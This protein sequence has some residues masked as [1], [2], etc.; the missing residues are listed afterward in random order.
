RNTYTQQN[1]FLESKDKQRKDLIQQV[2]D[3]FSLKLQQ[4]QAIDEKDFQSGL[5]KLQ[6][7][8]GI[9]GT[10]GN[11]SILN[12]AKEAALKQANAAQSGSMKLAMDTVAEA[13]ARNPAQARK[14]NQQAY[15]SHQINL[16]DYTKNEEMIGKSQEYSDLYKKVGSDK[17]L[18]D[19]LESIKSTFATKSPLGSSGAGGLST[20]LPP[21]EASRQADIISAAQQSFY[22][23]QQNKMDDLYLSDPEGKARRSNPNA[24]EMKVRQ[25]SSEA[26]DYARKQAEVLANTKNT[27]TQDSNYGEHTEA[28]NAGRQAFKQILTPAQEEKKPQDTFIQRR[29]IN[30][31]LPKQLSLVADKIFTGTEKEQKQAAKAYVDLYRIRGF[32]P[33]LIAGYTNR[34]EDDVQFTEKMAPQELVKTGQINPYQDRLFQSAEQFNAYKNNPTKLAA[35]FKGLGISGKDQIKV[36]LAQDYLVKVFNPPTLDTINP[37]GY[38]R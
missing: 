32:N 12:E 31:T 11:L 22:N 37:P 30:E 19:A 33:D 5:K 38:P 35:F 3:D 10:S 23:Y 28:V 26:A 21:Q 24:W 8:L 6:P 1:Q 13:A 16:G 4:G 29:F 17:L 36:M 34:T 20:A 18:N 14:L 2:A 7:Y 25:I 15:E 9:Y 27:V